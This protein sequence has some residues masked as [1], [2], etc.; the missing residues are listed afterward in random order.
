MIKRESVRVYEVQ[1]GQGDVSFERVGEVPDGYATVS[2][3]KALVLAHS[4]SGHDHVVDPTEAILY[5]GRDPLRAYLVLGTDVATVHHQK[6]YD[7]HHSIGL[8]GGTGAVWEVRR[9][10]E[11]DPA[12]ERRAAD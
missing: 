6:G 10:R 12:G 9:Q 5:E 7:F 2:P 4:E 8:G 11:W 1:G 3:G